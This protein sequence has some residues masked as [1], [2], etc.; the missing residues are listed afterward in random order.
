MERA[1]V[2]SYHHLTTREFEFQLCLVCQDSSHCLRHFHDCVSSLTQLRLEHAWS[3][4]VD[5]C[6][7]NLLFHVARPLPALSLHSGHEQISHRAE[8]APAGLRFW[9][10]AQFTLV[11]FRALSLLKFRA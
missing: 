5:A 8:F 1:S 4:C 6:D 3:Q 7:V 2:S 10:L 9:L 11:T